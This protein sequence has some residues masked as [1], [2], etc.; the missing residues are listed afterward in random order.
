VN[1]NK[2]LKGSVLAVGMAIG[3]L[4]TTAHAALIDIG[5]AIDESG[6][7][8]SSNYTTVKTGL[9]NALSLIP[10][11]GPDQYRIAVVSF[12]TTAT[13]IIAPPTVVTAANL[14]TLQATINAAP[15][16]GGGTAIHA[17][18]DR[19]TQLFT[20]VGLGDTTLFNV[21]TDGQSSI[22]ALQASATAAYNAGVDGLSF[23]GIGGG[24]NT[25]GLLSVA[26][27]TPSVLATVAT[28]PDPT[29]HGFVLPIAGFADYQAA[30]NAKVQHIVNPTI[31]LPAALPLM[32]SGFG[33]MGFMGWR[34]RKAA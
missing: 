24:V 28:I 26:F 18:V 4:G 11:S 14:A 32:A 21:S 27:P 19:L 12:D 3:S 22:T 8:G 31:P 34:R 29:Q 7:I 15:Y 25:A 30:I 13:N 20:A 23:E 17:G 10:T 5:F 9:A 33:L 6:S 16:N 1:L 2:L